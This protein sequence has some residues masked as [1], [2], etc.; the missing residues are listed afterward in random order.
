MDRVG[1]CQ[2]NNLMLSVKP[3]VI[4]GYDPGGKE[5]LRI[6]FADKFGELLKGEDLGL[7]P[8]FPFFPSSCCC[9][10]LG[11]ESGEELRN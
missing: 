2:L 4:I 11:K 9:C 3:C 5:M 10:L 8:P 6:E 7:I 1:R